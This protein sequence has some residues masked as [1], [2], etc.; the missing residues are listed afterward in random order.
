MNYTLLHNLESNVK[1]QLIK[2]YINDGYQII[3]KDQDNI[4]I[5]KGNIKLLDEEKYIKIVLSTLKRSSF[6]KRSS[7]KIIDLTKAFE[8]AQEKGKYSMFNNK[9]DWYIRNIMMKELS[10]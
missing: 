4:I 1:E 7:G 5:K 6:I 10:N 9:F 8:Y 3:Y 2:K